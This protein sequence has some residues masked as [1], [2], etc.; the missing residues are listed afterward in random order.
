ML[1]ITKPKVAVF[2][3]MAAVL[4]LLMVMPSLT[5]AHTASRTE[6]HF[7]VVKHYGSYN[8]ASVSLE[9]G[10]T[11]TENRSGSSMLVTYQTKHG[12][13]PNGRCNS[14]YYQ[15]CFNGWSEPKIKYTS[16]GSN[17]TVTSWS[18]RTCIL[19]QDDFGECYK[20]SV[21][22][23]WHSWPIQAKGSVKLGLA[24]SQNDGFYFWMSCGCVAKT[25]TM[26][27]YDVQ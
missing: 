13:V 1:Q 5:E 3:A 8:T 10:A 4:V 7:D 20:S 6:N 24:R 19:H 14:G 12:R 18:T 2:A 21:T 22:N 16:S 11:S 9:T 17:T 25:L 27:D 26:N 23:A 15:F